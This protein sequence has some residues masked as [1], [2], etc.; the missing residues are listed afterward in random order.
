MITT[1]LIG[2]ILLLCTIGYMAAACTTIAPPGYDAAS[3]QR[4]ADQIEWQ[5]DPWR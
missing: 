1:R 3:E 2:L 5:D 4:A